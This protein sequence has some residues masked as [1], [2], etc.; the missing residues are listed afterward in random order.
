MS[1]YRHIDLSAYR[2]IDLSAYRH[3]DM[4]TYRHMDMS[5][6]PLID[7]SAYRHIHMWH[8]NTYAARRISTP[9]DILTSREN[10]A[11]L[12]F[13]FGLDPLSHTRVG[14]GT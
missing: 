6:Y 8:T 4:S 3:M 11:V 7:L 14:V 10:K 13:K 9:S 5:T 1:T 12:T 2:L